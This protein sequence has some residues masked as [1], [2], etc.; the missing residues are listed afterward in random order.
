MSD[1][2]A[3]EATADAALSATSYNAGRKHTGLIDGPIEWTECV[4]AVPGLIGLVRQMRSL[5]RRELLRGMTLRQRE[6]LRTIAKHNGLTTAM[7]AEA[8]NIPT[9]NTHNRARRLEARGFV[10]FKGRYP[11]TL[12]I[13]P[14]GLM[15]LD[16]IESAP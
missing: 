6:A 9:T 1:L 16:L 7:F 2:K 8:L 13:T 5:L 12:H 11:S 4:E 3:L 14:D 15:A 10:S